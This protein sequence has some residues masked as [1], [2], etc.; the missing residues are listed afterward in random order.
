MHNVN[1]SSSESKD[2]NALDSAITFVRFVVAESKTSGLYKCSLSFFF[3]NFLEGVL[4]LDFTIE[5]DKTGVQ[6]Q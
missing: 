2:G 5:V 1:L 4:R 3:S 6:N